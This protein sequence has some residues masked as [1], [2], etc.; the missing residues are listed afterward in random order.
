MWIYFKNNNNNIFIIIIIII[1]LP[2]FMSIRFETTEPWA[3]LKRSPQQEEQEQ[4]E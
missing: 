4:D 3:F 1:I 2:N